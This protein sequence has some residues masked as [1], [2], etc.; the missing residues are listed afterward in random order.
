MV[1]QGRRTGQVLDDLPEGIMY[2]E[3]ISGDS[4]DLIEDEY[5]YGFERRIPFAPVDIDKDDVRTLDAGTVGILTPRK[6]IAP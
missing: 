4:A 6:T 2:L 3:L 5:Q 1:L